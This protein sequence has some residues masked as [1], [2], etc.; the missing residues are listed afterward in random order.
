M[1]PTGD[2]DLELRARLRS[3]R[4]DPPPGDFQAA[5]RRRLVAAGP[6]APPSA[7][8]RIREALG[9]PRLAW[10]TAAVA[11]AVAAYLAVAPALP[12]RAPAPLEAASPPGA[13]L[14]ATRV[15][16]VRLNLS[17]DV[18]VEAARIRVTLPPGLSF[19][20][21]DGELAQR[22]FE[23]TQALAAGDNEIPIAVRGRDPGRYRIA[24]DARVGE[25]RVEDEIWIEV[26]GG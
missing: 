10:G 1:S 6:P 15:A 22:S 21:E 8:A 16:V 11:A 26:V 12:G 9:T 20:A 18:P 4:T 13:V 25:Q 2:D 14:P 17:A 19:W 24:V 3:L 7:W 23:W 5:L